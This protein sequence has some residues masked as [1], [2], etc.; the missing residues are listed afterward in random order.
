MRQSQDAGQA[1]ARHVAGKGVHAVGLAGTRVRLQI[2]L[3]STVPGTAAE[4]S[5]TA[6]SCTA[7]LPLQVRPALSRA[8]TFRSL[9]ASRGH[10]A[11]TV[12]LLTG[13]A[14]SPV[15][16]APSQVPFRYRLVL[17]PLTAGRASVLGFRLWG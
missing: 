2:F 17:E 16:T 1:V 12:T 5:V 14:R 13:W 3:T 7:G 10:V 11:S 9:F 4:V 6:T 15:S 8:Q